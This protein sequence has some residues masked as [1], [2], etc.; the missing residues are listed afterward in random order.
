MMKRWI[1]WLTRLRPAPTPAMVASGSAAEIDAIL[2]AAEA[3]LARG[4]VPVAPSLAASPF[5]LG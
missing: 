5:S 2:R 1:R 3:Q 4:N